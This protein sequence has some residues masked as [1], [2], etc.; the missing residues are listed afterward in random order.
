MAILR[1]QEFM[2]GVTAGE[3][4]VAE[5]RTVTLAELDRELRWYKP[6]TRR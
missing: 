2:A 5:G 3:Q 4:A 1:D 6:R